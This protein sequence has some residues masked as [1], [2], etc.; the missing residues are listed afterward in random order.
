MGVNVTGWRPGVHLNDAGMAEAAELAEFLE[1]VPVAAIYSSPLERALETAAPL[2]RRRSM[3]IAQRAEF[4]EVRYGDWQGRSYESLRSDP[5]WQRFTGFRSSTRPPSGE[6]MLE[7]QA[8]M[9]AALC[10]VARWHEG[11]TIAVFSHGDAIRCA[12]MHFLGIPLD[13]HLRIE[14]QPASITILQ[15]FA[16]TASVR[17]INIRQGLQYYT[18]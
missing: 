16:D 13:F 15:L 11:Q 3:E 2:A 8:R 6:L 14:I 18:D 17:G 12:V 4:G 7:T 5:E 10:E 9:V 1:G